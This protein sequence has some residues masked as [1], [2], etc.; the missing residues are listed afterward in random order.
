MG[1]YGIGVIGVLM[2]SMVG[3]AS[4]PKPVMQDHEYMGFAQGWAGWQACIKAGAVTPEIGALG[5]RY[6]TGELNSRSYDAARLNQEVQKAIS[7]AAPVDTAACNMFATVVAEKKQQMEINRA[8]YQSYQQSLQNNM[9]V[10]PKPIYCT[11]VAG[12]TMCN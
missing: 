12:V 7:A 3:C 1:K 8:T 6:V 11:T 10:I 9:P 2:L 5:I 4:Q